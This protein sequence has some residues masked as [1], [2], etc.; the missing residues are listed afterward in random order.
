VLGLLGAPVSKEKDSTMRAPPIEEMPFSAFG[1]P[2]AIAMLC[3]DKAP[4]GKE[5][6]YLQSYHGGRQPAIR[7]TPIRN[8]KP[9]AATLR[10]DY[11]LLHL[12]DTKGGSIDCCFDGTRTLRV[13]GRGG[14]GLRLEHF[15][16]GPMFAT[17][18]RLVT[19]TI[20]ILR[21]YQI[22]RLA[23]A[24]K[25][26][27][28]WTGM[29]PSG[30]MIVDAIGAGAK[31]RSGW[32]IAIDE[33]WSTWTPR[34]RA[35]FR[36]CVAASR[37]HFE[38]WLADAPPA[39]ER[40]ANTRRNA[41]YL[42][43]S[44]VVEPGGFMRRPYMLMSKNWMCNVWS[45]DHC[46]NAIALAA[47]RADLAWDQLLLMADHQDEFGAYPDAINDMYITYN[48]SKPPVHG[49]ATTEV[50]RRNPGAGTAPRLRAMYAS[51]ER[52]THWWLT[53]RRFPGQT[54]PYYL[55]GNDSG[56]DNSTM[57]DQ[58][59][60]LKGPDLAAMLVLQME[61]L[62]D[63]ASRLKRP[64]DAAR[65]R[66]RAAAMLKALM[67]ELW[68]GNHFV[69]R[70]ARTGQAVESRS[71]IPCM[72]ILLGERL[73]MPV[74][75]SLARRIE[76]SL[77]EYGPATEQPT[78]PKYTADGYWRGPIWG[79]STYLVVCGLERA[80]RAELALTIAE[81][82]CR[83]CAQS[84]FAENFN[85]LTGAPLRDPAYTWTSS[86]FLLLAEKLRRK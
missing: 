75:D 79:P 27:G 83:L 13:R 46:F 15:T 23:G 64:A 39:P 49:W 80:G 35:S 70:L 74:I 62:A 41:A 54:L 52:W 12:S 61:A 8:G 19:M 29:N 16:W 81:R 21:R 17:S 60:P 63:I 71:L 42:N 9:V 20:N 33:Y 34:K 24:F 11:A 78:S 47:G 31:G 32:E 77:T 86:V 82:Y 22:E 1:S 55:H 73:P 40:L 44:C 76:E 14:L 3:G 85:A 67:T 30:K 50:L 56:W 18:D 7:M 45:W 4:D 26:D 69:A 38:R 59:V 25:A 58:G 53:Y 10:R 43:W 36:D 57:F 51:L 84:G 6:L 66:R 68:Q 37:K 65:W 2:F 28:L 5:G 48:Y 72:P